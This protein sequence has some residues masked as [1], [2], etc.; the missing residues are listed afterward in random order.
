[1]K[2]HFK[3]S[4]FTYCFLPIKRKEKNKIANKKGY[5]RMKTLERFYQWEKE[6]LSILIN[7]PLKQ[8]ERELIREVTRIKR[9][10]TKEIFNGR[11]I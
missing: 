4:S 6:R 1:M 9:N 2:N 10:E 8:W 5:S 7:K 11:R 3:I